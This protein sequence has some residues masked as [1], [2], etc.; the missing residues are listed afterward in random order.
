MTQTTPAAAAGD[1]VAYEYLTVRADRDLEPLY[2]DA[3]ASFGWVVEGYASNVPG[4][5]GVALKLKRD[6]RIK[7]RPMVLELQRRCE[8]ALASIASLERSKSSTAMAVSL[9]TGILG[10][11]FLAGSVFSLEA[12]MTALS[13]VLGA[14]G[15]IGW[16]VGYL[17]HGRVKTRRTEQVAPL[18]DQQYDVVYETGEQAAHLLS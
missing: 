2:R 3:Y 17:A 13:I 15:L 18:I 9:G 10:S 6:R 12:D 4:T 16:V 8:H 7:N 5:P 11:A 14:I 1:F